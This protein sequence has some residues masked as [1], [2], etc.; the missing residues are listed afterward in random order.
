MAD[1]FGK[2][3]AVR[4]VDIVRSSAEKKSWRKTERG[5]THVIYVARRP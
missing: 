2:V 3:V 4:L 5:E 1:I